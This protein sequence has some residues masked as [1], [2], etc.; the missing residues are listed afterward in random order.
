M[1][2]YEI[3]EIHN[4][5]SHHFDNPAYAFGQGPAL[6]LAGN[7][8]PLNNSGISRKDLKNYTHNNL[9]DEDYKGKISCAFLEARY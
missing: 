8:L 6:P 7:V 1:I 9:D 2:S 4:T 3:F 5:D